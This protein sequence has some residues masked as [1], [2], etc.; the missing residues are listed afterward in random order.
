MDPVSRRF[1]WKHIDAI[2]ENRVVILTTHAMEEADLLA[3]SVAVSVYAI[4]KCHV[5]A[6]CVVG[7]KLW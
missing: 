2:K 7:L 3:D 4:P 1:V 6:V 5:S